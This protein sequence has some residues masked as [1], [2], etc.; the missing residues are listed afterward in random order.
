VLASRRGATIRAGTPVRAVHQRGDR[1]HAV[2]TAAGERIVAGAVVNAAGAWADRVR[3][4]AG[5]KRARAVRASRGVHVVVPALTVEHALLLTAVRDRRVFFVMPSAHGSLV[6]T[7]ETE[8][9]DDP[10]ECVVTVSEVRYLLDEVRR[11][12][13]RVVQF[14]EH[15][16]H[17]YAGLRP[18][19]RSRAAL[20]AA[21]RESRLLEENGLFTVIGGKYTTYRAVAERTLDRVLKT[22]GKT[23]HPCSTRERPLPGAGA[24]TRE[25]AARAA[26]ERALELKQ[27]GNEDAA[28]LGARY[29]GL[30]AGAMLLAEQFRGAHE[31][32]GARVL[33]GEV[34][35]SVRHEMARC[36]D[37]V[38]FRRLGLAD[39]RVSARSAAVP[40]SVWMAEHLGWSRART[41]EEVQSV[42]RQLDVED[43]VIMGALQS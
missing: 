22:L 27:V 11:R 28:R 1:A 8:Y 41:Q 3:E 43:K 31:R 37:D 30:A 4:R 5:I 33:E 42:E 29:G 24:G 14:P 21:S 2:E 40:V 26:R 36:L 34:V 6:G 16:R 25:Q 35:Y 18:L 38:L 32:G 23:A 9:K 20:R 10:D 39:D 17:A 13:P 12:W 7:T 19:V 15:V